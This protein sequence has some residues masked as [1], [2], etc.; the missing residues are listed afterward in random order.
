MSTIGVVVFES[1]ATQKLGSVEH[2][3]QFVAVHVVLVTHVVP[4]EV[5]Y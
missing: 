3:V 2:F 5:A 1:H 4:F